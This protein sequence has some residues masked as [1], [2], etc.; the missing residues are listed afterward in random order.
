MGRVRRVRSRF[1]QWRLAYF[2]AMR[3]DRGD[4][5]RSMRWHNPARLLRPAAE[6]RVYFVEPTALQA[7]DPAGA[8]ATPSS[9]GLDL[10]PDAPD[11]VSTRG[12]KDLRLASTGAPWPL[13]HLARGPAGWGASHGAYLKRCGAADWAPGELACFA[14]DARLSREIEWLAAKGLHA[15]A[16]CT[17]YALAWP[18]I[19]RRARWFHLATSEV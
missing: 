13:V 14:L 4:V 6:L 15:G 11:R 2:A 19:L 17:I 18:G 12:R 3:G 8:P 1:R 16:T 7:L 9:K 10:S 5:T